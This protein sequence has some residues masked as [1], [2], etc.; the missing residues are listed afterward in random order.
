MCILTCALVELLSLVGHWMSWHKILIVFCISSD[1]IA[2]THAP[3][4]SLLTL[5]RNKTNKNVA[6]AMSGAAFQPKA[7]SGGIHKISFP[8]V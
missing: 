5:R 2:L 4:T 6:G 1:G 7:V 3:S 8:N